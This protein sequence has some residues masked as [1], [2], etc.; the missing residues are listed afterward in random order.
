MM[1]EVHSSIIY[2]IYF[3]NFCKCHSI[4]LPSTTVKKKKDKSKILSE[5]T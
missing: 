2:L 3:K 1:E 5:N 4:P